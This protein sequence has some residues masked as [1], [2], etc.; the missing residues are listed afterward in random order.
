MATI[1][2]SRPDLGEFFSSLLDVSVQT[3]HRAWRCSRPYIIAFD[4]LTRPLSAFQPLV[5]FTVLRILGEADARGV[6]GRV[7]AIVRREGLYLSALSDWRLRR[8]IA[9]NIRQEVA[10]VGIVAHEILD[11]E[12]HSWRIS[13]S[14]REASS[15]NS[16]QA[17]STTARS[18]LM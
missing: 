11:A 13:P 3:R 1:Q 15:R 9:R 12:S 5:A 18:L 16:L 7:G 14:R 2:P 10:K 17:R 4:V 8:T 6:P